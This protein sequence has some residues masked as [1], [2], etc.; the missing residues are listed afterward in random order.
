MFKTKLL[1]VSR[2]SLTSFGPNW[3]GLQQRHSC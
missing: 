2:D 3:G 1:R